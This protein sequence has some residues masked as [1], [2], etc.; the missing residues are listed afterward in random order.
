[1]SHGGEQVEILP[2]LQDFLLQVRVGFWEGD[3][4]GACIC[5]F[6]GRGEC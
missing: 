6:I 1:M 3:G 2:P 4:D 5:V